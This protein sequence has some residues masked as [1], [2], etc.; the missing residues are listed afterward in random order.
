MHTTVS[1]I[2][3]LSRFH[4]EGGDAAYA[5]YPVCKGKQLSCSNSILNR[6]GEFDHVLDVPGSDFVFKNFSHSL[7]F[8]LIRETDTKITRAKS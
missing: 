7:R 5:M 2:F 3:F 1:N 6:M 8:S 4:N